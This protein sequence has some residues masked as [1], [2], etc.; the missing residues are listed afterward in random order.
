MTQPTLTMYGAARHGVRA[1]DLLHAL[2]PQQWL[3][4]ALVFLP[5]LLSHHIRSLH[6]W[7]NAWLA[8]AAF[9]LCAS[10]GYIVNDI[11][12]RHQD[13][14][15]P[16]RKLRPIAAGNVPVGHALSLLPPLLLLAGLCVAFLPWQSGVVLAGYLGAT[17]FYSAVA[18][19]R[20]MADVIVLALLYTSRLFVG[21]FATGNVVSTWLAGFSVTLFLSI[22]LCKR[23]SELIRWRNRQV[24]N[25][26]GR[27]YQTDDIPVLEMMAV[28]SGFLACLIMMLYVQSTEILALYRHPQYLWVGVIGLLY[29]LGRL[30]IWTH[31]GKCPDDPLFF[32]VQD[33]TTLLVLF[34]ASVFAVLAI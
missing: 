30:I 28:S 2:R 5:F 29:W 13:R 25:A 3:K 12:D 26:P 31:R 19:G 14:L 17:V 9:S 11:R 16:V 7:G 22:A 33:K 24:E 23:V 18:K 6:A 15:H 32:A 10:C 4:N 27:R 21:S 1:A 20:L 8:F 34:V